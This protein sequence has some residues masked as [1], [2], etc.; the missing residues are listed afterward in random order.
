M[1]ADRSTWVG[2]SF[3][4]ADRS[5]WV[6]SAFVWNEAENRLHAQ[7]ALLELLVG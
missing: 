5:T 6:G 3:G 1:A 4:S 2:S 7:K